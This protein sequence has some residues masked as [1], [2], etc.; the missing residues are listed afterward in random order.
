MFHQVVNGKAIGVLKQLKEE[1]MKTFQQANVQE[2]GV[3]LPKMVV[4]DAALA[5]PGKGDL[6]SFFAYAAGQCEPKPNKDSVVAALTMV[7]QEHQQ[8]GATLGS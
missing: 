4:A 6:C 1:Y 8:S 7:R 5:E 2:A 3:A